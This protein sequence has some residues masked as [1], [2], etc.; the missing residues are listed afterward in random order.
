MTPDDWWDMLPQIMPL[1]KNLE[2]L[3]YKDERGKHCT[4]FSLTL[5]NRI[6]DTEERDQVVDKSAVIFN[7]LHTKAL[8]ISYFLFL[9]NDVLEI[10]RFCPLLDP[11]QAMRLWNFAGYAPN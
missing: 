1:C 3:T 5:K 9:D 11:S 4:K 8:F 6:K 2:E 10:A 7:E